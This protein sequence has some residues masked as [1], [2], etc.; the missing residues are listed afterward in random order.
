[1]SADS[2]QT[3]FFDDSD[4]IGIATRDDDGHL[5]SCPACPASW[6]DWE[7][8]D[9]RNPLVEHLDEFHTPD[10]FGLSPLRGEH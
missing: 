2:I 5:R 8:Q 4:E 9:G 10:D 6:S 1:M 7:P 3:T